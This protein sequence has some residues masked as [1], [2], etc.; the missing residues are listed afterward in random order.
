MS[1]P[2]NANTALAPIATSV[3][4]HIVRSIVD[5]PDAVKVESMD[6]EG[7]IILEVRVADGDL[8]RVIGRRG[9]TAQSIR[10]VVRAAASRDNAEVDVDF[11]D[12]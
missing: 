11:L 12:D 5:T 2:V 10:A 7:K 6:D 1:D 9:R 3:L 4:T 8:G